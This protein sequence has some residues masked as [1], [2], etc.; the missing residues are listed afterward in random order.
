MSDPLR[1]IY[2]Y[3]HNVLLYTQYKYI[4]NCNSRQLYTDVEGFCIGATLHNI[5][6]YAVLILEGERF[7]LMD[8]THALM[9]H[10]F[11]GKCS[12]HL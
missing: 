11:I 10:V 4:H 8:F 1:I 5:V 6:L 3:P 2:T 9:K 7:I 12:L